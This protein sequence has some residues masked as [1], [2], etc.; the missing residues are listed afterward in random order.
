MIKLQGISVIFNKGMKFEKK[1]LDDISLII[2]EN[3]SVAIRGGNGAGKSTLVKVIA[4]EIIAT[5]GKIWIGNKDYTKKGIVERSSMISRVFQDHM[6]G[7]ALEMT[8]MENMLFAS[9]RAKKRRL[10]LANNQTYKV[11]F[12]ERLTELNIGL[13]AKLDH[14]V[15]YL[16]GGQRQ[17]LSLI[18]ATLSDCKLLILDEHTSALDEKTADTVMKITMELIRKYKIT[19]LM[20][21]HDPNEAAL[22]DQILE[23]RDGK[24]YESE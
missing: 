11:G 21:T 10:I 14:Q 6:L 19:T 1:V 18:M 16:S 4:G 3:R 23:I 9:K 15:K 22:C 12:L 7:A 2:Q 20:I 8:V 13:E 24:I 17:A 5:K